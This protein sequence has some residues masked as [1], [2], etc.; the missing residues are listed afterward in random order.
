M[1]RKSSYSLPQDRFI[2]SFVSRKRRRF[3][4][5]RENIIPKQEVFARQVA[6]QAIREEIAEKLLSY[7]GLI[8]ENVNVSQV[9]EEKE[10]YK[11]EV[12]HTQDSTR[13]QTDNWR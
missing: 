6:K 10:H 3:Q 1:E 7:I 9:S 12:D 8:M 11:E 4:K 5:W 2:D 13:K